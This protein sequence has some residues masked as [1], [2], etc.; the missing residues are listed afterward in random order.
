MTERATTTGRQ[1]ASVRGRAVGLA[2]ACALAAAA[3]TAAPPALA[4]GRTG[5]ATADTATT[6][7]TDTATTGT[8]GAD[9][10]GTDTA[11]NDPRTRYADASIRPWFV[12][13]DGSASTYAGGTVDTKWYADRRYFVV[14]SDAHS[15]PPAIDAVRPAEAQARDRVALLAGRHAGV[16]SSD[17]YPLPGVLSTVVPRG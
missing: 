15:V 1:A 5:P 4:D 8:A 2:A 3:L 11:A 12:L 9:T 10:R 16:V 17:W 13:F 14:M 7:T 6:G